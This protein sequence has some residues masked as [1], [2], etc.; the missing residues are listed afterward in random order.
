[1]LRFSRVAP[2]L[3]SQIDAGKIKLT[4]IVNTHQYVF[5]IVFMPMLTMPVTGITPVVIMKL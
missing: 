4:S 5:F 3:K 1:M 2:T